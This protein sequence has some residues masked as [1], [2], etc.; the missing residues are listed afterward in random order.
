[1][2][3]RKRKRNRKRCLGGKERV[4]GTERERSTHMQGR[5]R[6]REMCKG[7]M[8]GKMCNGERDRQTKKVREREREK[9]IW[10]T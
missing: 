3:G 4:A 10:H 1:M 6:K 2:Q 8:R 9:G 7:E 5:E